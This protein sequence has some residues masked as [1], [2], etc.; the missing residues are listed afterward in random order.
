MKGKIAAALIGIAAIV[1]SPEVASCLSGP[2]V[3]AIAKKITVRIDGQNTGSGV[4]IDRKENIYFV[5]TNWHVVQEPGNYTVQTPDGKRYAINFSLIRR[6]PE[7]DLAV[8]LFSSSQ[9]YQVGFSGNSDQLT[10]GMTVYVAGW[11]DPGPVIPE[12]TYQFITGYISSRLQKPT[13]GY[14][15]V[16]TIN[17]VPGMSGGPVLDDRGDVVGIN[18]RAIPDIRTGTVSFVLGIGINNYLPLANPPAVA[19]L[20]SAVKFFQR[21]L[22]KARRGDYQGALA[23]YNQA[24]QLDP[25]LATVYNNRGLARAS[26]G[27]ISGALAD[28]NQAIQLNFNFAAPYNNR[29]LAHAQQGKFRE[30]LADYNQAIVLDPNLAETYNNRGLTRFQQGD[31]SGAVAD[32]NQALQL[33][34]KLA[35]AYGNRGIAKCERGDKQ[36]AI[37]DFQQ[38]ANLF[39]QQGNR[40]DYQR[41]MTIIR[42]L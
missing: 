15:L 22:D 38:A 7:V 18:G 41:I 6:V 33:N 25:N 2:E 1:V 40:A 35:A 34:P 17:A 36:G 14:S 37:K 23:D 27:D 19:T 3:N 30:A 29:G 28:Y 13:D 31:I 32:Y 5:L 8:L 10:E 9:S 26:S 11:A 20:Q 16:Y 12:R 24:L 4:I 21:G 39:L 42:R